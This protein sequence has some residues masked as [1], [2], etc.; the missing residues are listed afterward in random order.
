MEDARLVTTSR[1]TG[2]EQQRS[3]FDGHVDHLR[4]V[5]GACE[6]LAG[7]P[8]DYAASSVVTYRTR[9]AAAYVEDT[10]SPQ[11]NIRV[12]GGVRWELMH[13][14]P[15]L[16][17][18]NEIAPRLGMSWDVL[19]G[20]RSRLWASMGRSQPRSHDGRCPRCVES[21]QSNGRG[22]WNPRA[23]PGAAAHVPGRSRQTMNRGVAH[24]I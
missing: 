24:G 16:S 18:G 1:F 13:V 4:Y 22:E 21:S 6:E 2:S 5:A 19:G 17:F 14:G 11:P 20:G 9:Y 8:C 23:V 3:L 7:S 10:F 15:N 12:D